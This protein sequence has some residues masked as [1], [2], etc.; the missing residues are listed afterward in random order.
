M[1]LTRKQN[2]LTVEIVAQIRAWTLAFAAVSALSRAPGF[3]P[4]RV[5]HC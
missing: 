3:P 2:P 1:I 4:G 5:W